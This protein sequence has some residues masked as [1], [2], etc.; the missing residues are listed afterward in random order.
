[1]D[2]NWSIL[3]LLFVMSIGI[4]GA[5]AVLHMVIDKFFG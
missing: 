4:L 2:I 5:G 3:G 1:M